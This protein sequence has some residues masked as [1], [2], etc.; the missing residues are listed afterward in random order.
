MRSKIVL[1]CL[2]VFLSISAFPQ[3]SQSP[4]SSQPAST[5]TPTAADIA[6]ARA[7]REVWVNLGTG[8]YHRSGRWYGKTK[9]GKFMTEAEAKKGGYKPSK[10]S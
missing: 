5:H 7:A 2:L 4:P 6:A 3:T 10:R 1:L 8:V 9:N